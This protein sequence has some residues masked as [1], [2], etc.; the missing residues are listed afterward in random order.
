[1][2]V[3]LNRGARYLLLTSQVPPEWT[4]TGVTFPHVEPRGQGVFMGFWGLVSYLRG[5]SPY[6]NR[7]GSWTMSTS[8]QWLDP[9]GAVE[10][11][12]EVLAVEELFPAP[13][14]PGPGPAPAGPT[15]NK[16][17]R[18]GALVAVGLVA[19]GLYLLTARSPS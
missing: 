3:L 16:T 9:T 18:P 17:E 12:P 19:L 1:M 2:R 5:Q 13:A 14:L 6:D 8:G 10:L 15:F 11:G 7:P 4:A